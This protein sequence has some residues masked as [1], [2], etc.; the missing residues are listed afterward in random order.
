MTPAR[1]VAS[2]RVETA[3]RLLEET[4]DDLQAVSAR[5]GLGTAEAMRRVFQRTLGIAPGQYRDRFARSADGSVGV[6]D[7][8]RRRIP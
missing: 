4:D 5:S 2:I 6:S 8:A 7:A 3:R 1:Y